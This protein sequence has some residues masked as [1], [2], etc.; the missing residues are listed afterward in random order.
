MPEQ[1]E[2]CCLEEIVEFNEDGQLLHLSD[3]GTQESFYYPRTTELQIHPKTLSGL[4][5]FLVAN[6]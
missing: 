2:G 1:I 4:V 3:N 5:G 6:H